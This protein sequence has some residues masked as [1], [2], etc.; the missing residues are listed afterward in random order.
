MDGLAAESRGVRAAAIPL[1][2]ADMKSKLKKL[3]TSTVAC[4]A[5]IIGVALG[6]SQ[7]CTNDEAMRA[8][9]ATDKLK[10]WDSVYRFYR[11]YSHCDDGS[12]GEGVSDAVAKLFANH[13]DSFRAFVT[14][15]SK[16]KAFE[17]F[18]LRHVD[19]TIDW[20]ADAPKINE[21]ARQ[22]CPSD[23]VRLCR[24]LI[25]R[26]TPQKKLGSPLR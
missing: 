11:Q 18:V 17:K 12:V 24:V 22:R 19:E 26:T 8:E 20:S 13:W 23:S 9:M 21:N 16:D 14:L 4:S 10:T 5:V 15:A 25:S 6:Q 1:V 2:I 3:L 7:P